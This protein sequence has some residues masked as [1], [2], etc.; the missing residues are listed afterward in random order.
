[1]R[2]VRKMPRI[3]SRSRPASLTSLRAPTG[4]ASLA[5]AMS[6]DRT[7]T[8][9]A[10]LPVVGCP[11]FGQ[12]GPGRLVAEG[13]VDAG[14]VEGAR[15]EPERGRGLVVALEVGVEHRR[16]VGRDRAAHPGC[17]ESR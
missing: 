5:I 11:D 12:F 16:I 10:A 2:M 9:R 1:M 6:C 4:S 13:A 17:D 7:L 14:L 3:S 8:I 15:V